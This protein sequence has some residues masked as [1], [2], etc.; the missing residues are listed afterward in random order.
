MG[1]GIDMKYINRL[2]NSNEC[3]RIHTKY[4]KAIG[5]YFKD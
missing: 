1:L 3:K 2:L 4:L 5:E